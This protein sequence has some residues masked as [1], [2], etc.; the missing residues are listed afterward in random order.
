MQPLMVHRDLFNELNKSG[1]TLT[2]EL[3]KIFKVA[4]TVAGGYDRKTV[5]LGVHGTGPESIH[6]F[7]HEDMK[8]DCQIVNPMF[9]ESSQIDMLLGQKFDEV[10]DPIFPHS[11]KSLVWNH[12]SNLER[13]LENLTR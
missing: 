10:E 6:T 1:E 3:K 11:Q 12:E 13:C 4:L 8:E 7:Y 9:I 2:D 5:V